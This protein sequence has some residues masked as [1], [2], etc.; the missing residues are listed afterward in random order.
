[1]EMIKCSD[2]RQIEEEKEQDFAH[3]DGF[4]DTHESNI[5]QVSS[6]VHRLCLMLNSMEALL[7][8]LT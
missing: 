1:M 3:K 8:A 2:G 4:W 7:I 6:Y 5:Q